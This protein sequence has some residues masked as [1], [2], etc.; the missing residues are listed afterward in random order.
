M[1]GVRYITSL[2]SLFPLGIEQGGWAVQHKHFR[3]KSRE[4]FAP[5]FPS[6]TRPTLLRAHRLV[7]AYLLTLRTEGEGQVL[8]VVP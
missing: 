8:L 6:L 7:P 1:L 5:R 2:S 3:G 4:A